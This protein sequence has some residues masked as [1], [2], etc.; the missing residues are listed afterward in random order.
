MRLIGF[1][2]KNCW[3]ER[4]KHV[5][6]YLCYSHV[7]THTFLYS[8]YFIIR[9]L[10]K[11]VLLFV[12][13]ESCLSQKCFEK[14]NTTPSTRFSPGVGIHPLLDDSLPS[15]LYEILSSVSVIYKAFYSNALTDHSFV[16][17]C[18]RSQSLFVHRHHFLSVSL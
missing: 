8:L 1:Y 7:C 15:V 6:Q 18:Y 4:R 12:I 9:N 16:F 17:S 5:D 10:S 2:K 13:L 11:V 14:K 3:F